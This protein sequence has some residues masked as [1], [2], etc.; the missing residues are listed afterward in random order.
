MVLPVGFWE[1]SGSTPLRLWSMQTFV[2]QLVFIQLFTVLIR[3][4]IILNVQ[5]TCLL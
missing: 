5:F 1:L 4:A 3:T 2:V